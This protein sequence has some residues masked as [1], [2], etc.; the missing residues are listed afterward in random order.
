MV[1]FNT[2]ISVMLIRYPEQVIDLLPYSSTITKASAD[3]ED[4]PWLAYDSHFHKLAEANG[5]E[6]WSQV[7]S[8]LWTLY[9]ANSRLKRAQ[10][11]LSVVPVQEEAPTVGPEADK[12]KSSGGK[13]QVMSVRQES[14]RLQPYW[15]K[16]PQMCQQWNRAQGGCNDPAC[17]Y[18]HIYLECHVRDHKITRCPLNKPNPV[19]VKP[20]QFFQGF[21]GNLQ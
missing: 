17:T 4:T 18:Y 19:K 13:W 21:I 14:Q 5:R 11:S 2:Y 1:C 20:Q 3:Y 8:S 6:D 12:Q 16:G 7:E 15:K 9:F 10:E